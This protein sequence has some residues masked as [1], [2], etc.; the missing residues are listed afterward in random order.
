MLLLHLLD[1]FP[2]PTGVGLRLE[3]PLFGFVRAIRLRLGLLFHFRNLLA[4]LGVPSLQLK[5]EV[6]FSPSLFLLELLNT[7]I[8]VLVPLSSLV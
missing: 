5:V 3:S 2:T 7:L 6:V 8:V 4:R 1:G